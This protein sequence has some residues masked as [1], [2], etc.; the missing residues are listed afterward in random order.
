MFCAQHH[1]L[2]EGSGQRPTWR[3]LAGHGAGRRGPAAASPSPGPPNPRPPTGQGRR[4]VTVTRPRPPPLMAAPPPAAP[5]LSTPEVLTH[6]EAWAPTVPA[7]PTP[8]LR[9]TTSEGGEKELLTLKGSRAGLQ[10]RP[11]PPGTGPAAHTRQK[12]VVTTSRLE[13]HGLASPAHPRET[14]GRARRPRQLLFLHN[15]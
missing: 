6:P 2:L 1:P 8:H 14:P 12:A 15:F 4:A 3:G 9:E 5:A 11:P 13:K 7:Q 10:L